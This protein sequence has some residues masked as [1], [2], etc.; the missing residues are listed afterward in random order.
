[1]KKFI[2]VSIF[3][4]LSNNIYSQDIVLIDASENISKKQALVILNGFGDSK[5]NRKIQKAFFQDKGYDLFIPEY[6][7]RKSIDLSTS[8]FSDFY[9]KNNLDKYNEVKFLCY[10]IGGF[11]LNQHIEKNGIGKI[12][13]IIYDRSPTQ[14]RAPRAATEKLPF[15]SRILYGKVLSDFSKRKLTTLSHTDGL[16]I[17]VIIENKATKLMRVLKKTSDRYGDYNYNAVEIEG[18]L[19]DFTHTYLDH[20][21]MYKRFDIIGQEIVLFLRKGRFSENAKRE[22]YDWD[23]FKKLKKNDINL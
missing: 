8:T 16:T 22:K 1:M 5:K 7:E 2:Y 4:I 9:K 12:T 13:T 23:P 18:N 11:V 10:I 17:G 3:C 15:I 19:D 6:I 20:D 21:L 14:E